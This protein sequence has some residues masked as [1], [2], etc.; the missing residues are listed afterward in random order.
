MFS[1]VWLGCYGMNSLFLEKLNWQN[2]L[3]HALPIREYSEK[4]KK[5]VFLFRSFTKEIVNDPTLG[6]SLKKLLILQTLI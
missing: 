1:V 3:V 5:S 4:K 6:V 2:S